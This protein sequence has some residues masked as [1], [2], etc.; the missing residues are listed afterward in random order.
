MKVLGNTE[1]HTQRTASYDQ[2]RTQQIQQG[3][4]PGT[5][6]SS[7]SKTSMSSRGSSSSGLHR[8]T[9]NPNL[10]SQSVASQ[11]AWQSESQKAYNTVV[12]V[13]PQ[14]G[15]YQPSPGS[16]QF[17]YTLQNMQPGPAST[18]TGPANARLA[19]RKESQ[20]PMSL[21]EQQYI[22][23]ELTQQNRVKHQEQVRLL[24]N[25][26]GIDRKSDP[27]IL[28]WYML[29]RVEEAPEAGKSQPIFASLLQCMWI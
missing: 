15:T 14:N 5:E 17:H 12:G 21:Q 9:S 25:F 6:M 2:M 19:P 3:A 27:S 11:V 10:I 26:L 16:L 7:S 28:L 23:H 22:S 24:I 8:T 1:N 13:P 20:Q 29:E 4:G 18:Y